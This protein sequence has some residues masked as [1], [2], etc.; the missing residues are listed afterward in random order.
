ME[1]NMNWQ[2]AISTWE[3]WAILLFF[4]AYFLY[5]VRMYRISK[6]FKTSVSS[7]VIKFL[8]R[9]MTLAAL[10]GAL[11]GPLFGE[12]TREVKTIGKDI[13]MAI[14]LSES[15]NA[16]DIPPSRLE[17]VKFELKKIIGAFNSDRISLIIFSSEAFVQCPLTYDQNALFMFLE[18]L[19]SDLVPSTG[20]DFAPPLQ[21]AMKKISGAETSAGNPT[22]KI[23][24]LVSDGEDFGEETKDALKEIRRLGI[25]LFT[26]GVGTEAGSKIATKRGY[27]KDQEG[28]DVVTRLNSSPLLSMANETDG[29]Y[30]EISDRTNDINRLINHINSIEGEVRDSRM[31]DVSA[32]KYNYLL[33]LALILMAID[34]M[35][36]LK[37][38]KLV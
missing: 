18:A 21:L 28:N 16:F 1:M 31:M 37:T 38:I 19:N 17:K 3:V 23:I 36:S 13:Y 9:G 7:I 11:L 12:S 25:R 29:R 14:D 10:L 22:S 30:F 26:L 27:K 15:M 5:F 6:V 2:R 33:G 35:V 20:T 8:L 4:I 34:A 32:N 24:L